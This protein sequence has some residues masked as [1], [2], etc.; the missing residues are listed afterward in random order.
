MN[1]RMTKAALKT[2]RTAGKGS[3]ISQSVEGF[4]RREL[5]LMLAHGPA[6]CLGHRVVCHK[7]HFPMQNS[8]LPG[9][10][11]AELPPGH[12]V[13]V[14]QFIDRSFAREKSFFGDGIVAH[15]SMAHPVC[16]RLGD[17][18]FAAASSLSLP[19]TRGAAMRWMT[20]SV[21]VSCGAFGGCPPPLF[22]F[23][24]K[25]CIPRSLNRSLP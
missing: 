8:H 10:L 16:S 9:S 3:A 20:P 21:S 23:H 15:V 2:C 25:A 14:D 1:W 19:V 7:P 22:R 6:F 11:K 4:I 12:F 5:A 24:W 18:L 13:V 17:G